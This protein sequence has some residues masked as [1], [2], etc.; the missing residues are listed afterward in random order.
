MQILYYIYILYFI[1]FLIS[2]RPWTEELS[3]WMKQEKADV[4]EE[5]SVQAQEV[6]D[7]VDPGGGVDVVSPGVQELTRFYT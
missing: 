4:P 7:S 2:P 3:E 1:L 5:D 6:E